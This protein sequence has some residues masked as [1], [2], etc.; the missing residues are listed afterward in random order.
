MREVRGIG[1]ADPWSIDIVSAMVGVT[2]GY[3]LLAISLFATAG[4]RGKIGKNARRQAKLQ[5]L[6]ADS[7]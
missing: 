7:R 5:W 2:R 4:P 1:K 3:R 6:I